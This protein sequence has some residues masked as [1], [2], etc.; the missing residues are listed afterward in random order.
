MEILYNLPV[1]VITKIISFHFKP[2]N[3]LICSIYSSKFHSFY[4][5]RLKSVK[6]KESSNFNN[7]LHFNEKIFF[8]Y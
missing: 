4:L 1:I 7:K 6:I 5:Y 8:I 2:S 3:T